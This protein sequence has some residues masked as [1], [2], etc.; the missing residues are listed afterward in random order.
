MKVIEILEHMIWFIY[1]NIQ[2]KG[3]HVLV[4]LILK[5]KSVEHGIHGVECG[6]CSQPIYC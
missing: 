6:P 4:I 2:N 1:Y 5:L 3:S